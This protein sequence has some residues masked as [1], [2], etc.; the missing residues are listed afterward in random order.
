[1]DISSDF[2]IMS[3]GEILESGRQTPPRYQLN[4]TPLKPKNTLPPQPANENLLEK[5]FRYID[6]LRAQNDFEVFS[7]KSE[8]RIYLRDIKAPKRPLLEITT[9]DADPYPQV[10]NNSTPKTISR[11]LI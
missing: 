9:R 8:D 4:G 10:V 5:I 11:S 3:L 1:M 7:N 6:E 2:R